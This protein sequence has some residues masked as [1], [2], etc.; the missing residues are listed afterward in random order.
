MLSETLQSTK[1]TRLPFLEIWD[2]K[3]GGGGGGWGDLSV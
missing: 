2:R 1:R 3:S